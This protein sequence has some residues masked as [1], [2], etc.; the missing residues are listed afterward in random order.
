MQTV[1][2]NY[3]SYLWNTGETSAS[4]FVN[5]TGT[6]YV[7]V[8]RQACSAAD[9]IQVLPGDCDIY[10]PSA[11][12]PNK[13]NLNETFGVVDY[14]SVQYFSL[15]VYSKW[16]QLIFSSNDINRKWDG[17]FKGKNMPNGSYLWMLNYTNSR[18]RKFYDQGTVMLIR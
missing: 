2:S 11:F 3:D 17:T 8:S 1:S 6:Y 10:V 5:Q 15:Q 13:D 7:T 16:G 4:I 14:A 9:T 18:G 12:T